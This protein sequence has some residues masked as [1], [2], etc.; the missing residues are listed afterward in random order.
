M[1]QAIVDLIHRDRLA[2]YYTNIEWRPALNE[3]D[4]RDWLA[5]AYKETCSV[6]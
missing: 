3:L 6:C 5:Y 2:D 4:I 1:E